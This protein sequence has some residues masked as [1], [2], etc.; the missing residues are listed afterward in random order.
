VTAPDVVLLAGAGLAAGAVN[1]V[2]GGGS[3]I[4]FPALAATGMPA[5]TANVTNQV[6]VLP[7]YLGGSL[8]YR[9][10]LRPQRSRAMT[11]GTT[12]ACGA[13]IG[14]VLLVVSPKRLFAVLAPILVL[15]AVALLALRPALARHFDAPKPHE[16]HPRGLHVANSAASV[17][18]GYFGAG[19]GVMLLAVLAIAL[20]DTLQRL[21]ALKGLLSLIVAVVAAGYF[22]VFGPVRWHE[23]AVM[24]VASF[25]G[26]RL[27]V[28]AARRVSDR[29]LRLGVVAIETT[30]AVWLFFRL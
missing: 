22:A 29:A 5:L 30:V 11:L 6:A 24:A 15:L 17:Y 20:E 26:G 21:N 28:G 9:D 14:A 12:S 23:A 1:A 7:G 16:P 3:L 27:G 2:A 13:L 10:E 25:V 19:L 18:G 4:S 8:A